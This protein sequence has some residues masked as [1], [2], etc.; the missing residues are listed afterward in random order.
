LRAVLLGLVCVGVL[1]PIGD[2]NGPAG[3]A[4]RGTTPPGLDCRDESARALPGP[5]R[6]SPTRATAQAKLKRQRLGQQRMQLMTV[7]LETDIA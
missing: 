4:F 6:A 2:A 5:A 1:G 3:L 7:L